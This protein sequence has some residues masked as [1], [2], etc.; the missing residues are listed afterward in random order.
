[1][2]GELARD[3]GWLRDEPV[4]IVVEYPEAE[5]SILIEDDGLWDKIRI[6]VIALPFQCDLVPVPPLPL[7]TIIQNVFLSRENAA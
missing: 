1:M 2:I 6:N 4:D 7:D 5:E 3:S